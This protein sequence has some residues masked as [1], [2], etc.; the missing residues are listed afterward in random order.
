MHKIL[1]KFKKNTYC[2]QIWKNSPFWI[3]LH[4]CSFAEKKFT[5]LEK[6]SFKMESLFFWLTGN[7]CHINTLY[8]YEGAGR[9]HNHCL[10][11]ALTSEMTV[12]ICMGMFYLCAWY[13]GCTLRTELIAERTSRDIQWRSCCRSLGNWNK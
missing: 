2:R 1:L 4:P 11:S 6:G 3:R 9:A 12:Y 5:F 13:Q 8:A 7:E 10:H